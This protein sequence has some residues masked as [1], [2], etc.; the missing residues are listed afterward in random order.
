MNTDGTATIIATDTAALHREVQ[1]LLVVHDC[2]GRDVQELRP[3]ILRVA[4]QCAQHPHPAVR[5]TARQLLDAIGAT[6]EATR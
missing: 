1:A 5:R 3:E 6:Q 2:T 4:K